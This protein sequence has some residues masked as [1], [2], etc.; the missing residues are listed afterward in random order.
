[1]MV[2][3][4]LGAQADWT[5]DCCHLFCLTATEFIKIAFS[6][7][8]P[9]LEH[10]FVW[11]GKYGEGGIFR[12]TSYSVQEQFHTIALLEPCPLTRLG[13]VFAVT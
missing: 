3:H 8:L 6:L 4:I 7:L 9:L 11:G 1:M 5:P 13:G 10:K 12:H 2:H